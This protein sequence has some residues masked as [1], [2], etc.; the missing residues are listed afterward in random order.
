VLAHFAAVSEAAKAVR[1]RL[2]ELLI[3]EIAYFGQ[4]N[5]IFAA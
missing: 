5:C 3:G 2:H 4:E 1:A